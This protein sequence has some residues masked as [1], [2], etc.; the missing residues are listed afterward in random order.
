MESLVEWGY[1][2]LF[3]GAVIGSTIFPLSS[4][5]IL[6]ALLMQPGANPYIAISIA[7]VGNWLGGAITYYMGWLGRWDWI[8]RYF[9]ITETKLRKQRHIVDRWGSL[10]AAFSWLPIIGDLFPLA[11]GFYRVNFTR[12]GIYMFIGKGIRFIIWGLTYYWIEPIFRQYLPLFF[13]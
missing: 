5:V 11:L 10:L 4:E 8:E 3:L 2:G 1:L 7:T 13:E 9:H 6:L 12:C